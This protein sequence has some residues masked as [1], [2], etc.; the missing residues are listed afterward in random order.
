MR[1]WKF[2][3]IMV[4]LLVIC[5]IFFGCL[6]KGRTPGREA[7]TIVGS[8]AGVSSGSFRYVDVM[9]DDIDQPGLRMDLYGGENGY[10]CKNNGVGGIEIVHVDWVWC[11]SDGITG[12]N[13]SVTVCGKADRSGDSSHT[14]ITGMVLSKPGTSGCVCSAQFNYHSIPTSQDMSLAYGCASTPPWIEHTIPSALSNLTDEEQ[15]VVAG[16]PS[17]PLTNGIEAVACRLVQQRGNVF[18]GG[19][20]TKAINSVMPVNLTDE[21]DYMR[22][23]YPFM[24]SYVFRTAEA[25]DFSE[26]EYIGIVTTDAYQQGIRL[27]IKIIYSDTFGT[28]HIA[29]TAQFIAVSVDVYDP[30]IPA[31]A[32]YDKWTPTNNPDVIDPNGVVDS[33]LFWDEG[34]F[35]PERMIETPLIPMYNENDF[36]EIEIIIDPATFIQESNKWLSEDKTLDFNGDNIVNFKDVFA[37]F[38]R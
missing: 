1:D 19:Q 32:V 24:Y 30:N 2:W 15:A 35:M 25:M 28:T 31:V 23:S 8:G 38:N 37:V 17:E 16:G 11:E 14:G 26:K 5:F 12:S 27:P 36:I 3:L 6:P 13:G 7:C 10:Y 9:G 21:Y 18:S 29:R 34:N 33:T 20:W 4:V 22:Y